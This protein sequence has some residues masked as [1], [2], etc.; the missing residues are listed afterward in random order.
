M[1]ARDLEPQRGRAPGGSGGEGAAEDVQPP[2]DTAEA[3]CAPGPPRRGERDERPCCDGPSSGARLANRAND[4]ACHR[5]V[6]VE[7]VVQ[8]DGVACGSLNVGA[9]VRVPCLR[10]KKGATDVW[11]LGRR[12]P[13]PSRLRSWARDG[14]AALARRGSAC[15]SCRSRTGTG[16]CGRARRTR[17]AGRL[18]SARR[19]HR[20]RLRERGRRAGRAVGHVLAASFSAE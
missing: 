19:R 5:A 20:A 9:A 7:V 12:G 13:I 4:R 8:C 16:R 3:A 6:F 17:G 10:S 1:A 15:T 11:I 14:R 18:A 2:R